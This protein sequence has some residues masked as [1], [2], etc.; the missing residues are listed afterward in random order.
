MLSMLLLT[1]VD[2]KQNAQYESCEL[3]FNWGKMRTVG[4]EIAPQIA[5]RNC[6]KEAGM[7]KINIYVIF[8]EKKIHAIKH[9]F[10]QK[11]STC[12]MKPLLV[13]R[14]SHHHEGF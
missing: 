7:K 6:S 11:V 8:G 4:Q 10:F 5:L 1:L 3:S 12:L 9:I 13:T 14:K 2:L